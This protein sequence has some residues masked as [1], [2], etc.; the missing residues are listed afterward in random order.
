MSSHAA[1]PKS[2]AQ[3]RPGPRSRRAETSEGESEYAPLQHP[4]FNVHHL[5]PHVSPYIT[6]SLA[7]PPK[8]KHGFRTVTDT[9]GRCH[10][11][12]GHRDFPT[13]HVGN[14]QRFTQA[15]TPQ[16][17]ERQHFEGDAFQSICNIRCL[18]G[19]DAASTSPNGLSPIQRRN[20][21]GGRHSRIATDDE[22]IGRRGPDESET[23]RFVMRSTV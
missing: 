13:Y 12:K 1:P 11:A 10:Q 21:S 20:G 3:V 16:R 2:K 19:Q 23:S 7:A 6:H 15:R 9:H 14:S 22:N 18:Q 4:W 17:H 8:Q 5:N